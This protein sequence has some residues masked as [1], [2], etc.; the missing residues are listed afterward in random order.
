MIP[1]KVIRTLLLAAAVLTVSS[2]MST[3]NS[4]F[5]AVDQ[6]VDQRNFAGALKALS[7]KKMAE[8]YGK[9]DLVV[10]H[11]DF[12]MLQIYNETR[13]D[14]IQNLTTA[15]HLM[16]DYYTKSLSNIAASFLLN[17]TAMEYA[18]EDYEN[19]YVNVFKSLAFV[20]DNNF[21]GAFVEIRRVGDKLNL[22]E[23]KYR[24]LTDEANKSKDAKIKVTTTKSEFYNS[25]LAHWIS[26]LLYR[27]DGSPDDAALELKKINQAFAEQKNVYDFPQPDLSGSLTNPKAAHLN[28]IA[29]SGRAPQKKALTY[30]LNTFSNE[31]RISMEWE[32]N[33]GRLETKAMAGLYWPGAEAGYNFKCQ[34]PTMTI[35]ESPVKKVEVILDG[36]S[37]GYLSLLERMDKVAV[38]TFKL[39]EQ[40]TYIKTIIRTLV[41]GIAAQEAKKAANKASSGNSTMAILSLVGGIAA[42]VAVEASEM[43]DLRSARYL[44]GAAWTA[45]FVVPEGPHKLAVR[46]LDAAGNLILTEDLGQV[47]I[48][49]KGLNLFSSTALD[50]FAPLGRK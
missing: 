36:A 27:A 41:K 43:A 23:D 47:D 24:K 34:V 12:G 5:V 35:V 29:F 14:G 17:D 42:D 6:A 49:K 32:N 50:R 19:L 44:P 11:Y 48:K 30:R 4:A 15:E 33:A 37:L 10:K 31:V 16:E 38:A 7:D 13:K 21:D 20:K 25:A 45:D 3:R 40:F 26:L 9:N 22:L 46:Y 2:C 39:K 18:G 1:K 8:V 28:V